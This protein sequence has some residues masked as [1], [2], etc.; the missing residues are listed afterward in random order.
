LTQNEK[1]MMDIPIRMLFI[2]LFATMQLALCIGQLPTQPVNEIIGEKSPIQQE[3]T[4]PSTIFPQIH[5]NLNGMV[6]EFV[7][8]MYQDTK[9]NYWFGT[10]VNGIIRYNGTQLEK[11]TDE[12]WKESVRAIAEDK[13]G[14]VWFGTSSGLVKYDGTIFTTYSTELGLQSAD[15][16]GLTIDRSGLIWV[17]TVAG[18]SRFDGQKFTPFLLPSTLVDDPKTML[19]YKLVFQ[20]LEDRNGTLW[21][22][23]DGN[24][25]FTYESGEFAHLTTENGLPDNS[26]ADILEDRNGN[27][28]LGTFYGGVGRFDG[29]KYLNFTKDGMTQ[30]LEAYNFCEDKQGNIWFSAEGFGIYRYDGVRFSQFTTENGLTTNVVQSIFEDNKGQLWFSTWQG[31]SIYDGQ[32]FVNANAL[33]PWT[34]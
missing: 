7:R 1:T 18:V 4:K 17:G 3:V 25:I 15:I 19:S 28:W 33:E 2:W 13:A 22:V 6:T 26:V 8:T 29:K 34:H 12:N 23:M 11:V 5:T 31:L 14:N 21:F 20:I 10:N 24:G 27:V 9:G 16:W 30:G 32:R